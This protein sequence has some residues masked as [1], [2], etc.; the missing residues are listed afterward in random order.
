MSFKPNL[1]GHNRSLLAYP[2]LAISVVAA[3]SSV[4]I[5]F[6]ATQQHRDID[7]HRQPDQL[8]VSV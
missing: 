6:A 8:G 5:A 4:G 7:I 1:E 2:I 3:L